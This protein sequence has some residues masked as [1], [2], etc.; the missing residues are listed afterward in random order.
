MTSVRNYYVAVAALLAGGSA[1]ALTMHA[2]VVA[3]DQAGDRTAAVQASQPIT[4]R[5][6]HVAQTDDGPTARHPAVRFDVPAGRGA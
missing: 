5:A 1:L 3:Q 6:G 4:P 2:P